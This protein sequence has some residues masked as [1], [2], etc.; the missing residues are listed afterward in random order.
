MWLLHFVKIKQQSMK[1]NALSFAPQPTW[2]THIQMW[3]TAIYDKMNR[4]QVTGEKVNSRSIQGRD[5]HPHPVPCL[6]QPQ[7]DLVICVHREWLFYPK[8][9]HSRKIFTLMMSADTPAFYVSLLLPLSPCN[10]SNWTAD[11]KALKMSIS[12]CAQSDSETI[13]VGLNH[14]D[15][16]ST[17]SVAAQQK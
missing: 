9:K 5:C 15:K 2:K 17:F 14:D 7:W 11:T 6:W 4:S 3:T 12:H 16:Y 10:I 1:S 13:A 8:G